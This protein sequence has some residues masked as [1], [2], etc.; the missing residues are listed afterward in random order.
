MLGLGETDCQIYKT[1][2]GTFKYVVMVTKTSL[3]LG[4]GEKQDQIYGTPLYSK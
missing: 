2:E 3:M 1:V 4:L